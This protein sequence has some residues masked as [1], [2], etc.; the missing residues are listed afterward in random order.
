LPDYF[1]GCRWQ[2]GDHPSARNFPAIV[3][4]QDYPAMLKT[5]LPWAKGPQS[6]PAGSNRT[7]LSANAAVN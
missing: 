6:I 7:G 1:D 5:S 3:S 4:A 2:T